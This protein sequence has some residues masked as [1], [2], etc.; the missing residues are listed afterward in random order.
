MVRALPPPSLRAPPPVVV[1]ATETARKAAFLRSPTA[2]T[3][4][5][6][7]DG[8]DRAYAAGLLTRTADAAT[9]GTPNAARPVRVAPNAR[10]PVAEALLV[11][12]RAGSE[13]VLASSSNRRVPVGPRK[14]ELPNGRRLA[15]VGLRQGPSTIAGRRAACR[16]ASV[17]TL[18]V[19][20]AG[21]T[22]HPAGVGAP[23]P[24]C[25]AAPAA[26]CK[27]LPIATLCVIN[28]KIRIFGG[29]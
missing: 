25:P 4:N 8:R 3:A 23:V 21:P 11:A 13:A 16:S 6:Y 20:D 5:A 17:A 7:V 15:A 18:L 12:A 26:P 28:L 2:P 14:V 22:A 24:R 10:P 9:A 29:Q 1:V 19:V 27:F